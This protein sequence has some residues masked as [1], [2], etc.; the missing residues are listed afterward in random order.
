[1]SLKINMVSSEHLFFSSIFI[2][3]SGGLELP[4]MLSDSSQITCFQQSGWFLS[5]LV[6]ETERRYQEHLVWRRAKPL[7]PQFMGDLFTIWWQ[8]LT[9]KQA[10]VMHRRLL[11]GEELSDYRDRA[12]RACRPTNSAHT[13][14]HSEKRRALHQALQPWAG[15]KKKNTRW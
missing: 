7:N 8:P 5:G 4:V 2:C 12:E 14:M 1:M 3:S 10:A 6:S 13:H 11:R 15:K 9:A